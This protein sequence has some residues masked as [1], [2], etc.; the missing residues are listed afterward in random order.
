LVNEA[1]TGA[2]HRRPSKPS[3]LKCGH[4]LS[5]VYRRKYPKRVLLLYHSFTTNLIYAKAIRAELE[6]KTPNSLELY[7]GPLL[8]ASN[9]S[10]QDHYADYLHDRFRDQRLD[11]V[12]AIGA[13]AMSLFRRYRNQ[14]FP[15]TA[16]LALLEQR[17]IPLSNLT[18]NEAAI[19]SFT[20][21][22]V[23][24]DNIL[25]VLPE[26]T[27]VAVLIGNSLGEKYWIEQMRIAFDHI[28]KPCFLQLV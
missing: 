24:V 7:D 25:Q 27:N 12:V 26:T 15:S 1:R 19:G 18:T 23:I 14:F 5:W 2:D 6:R 9:D 22:T 11:L 20:N 17:R 28:R 4:A 10:V 21:F 16:L 3:P 8:P 13:D